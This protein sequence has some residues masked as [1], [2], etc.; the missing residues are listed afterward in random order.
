MR[1]KQFFRYL[2]LY[3]IMNKSK[4][5]FEKI[6]CTVEDNNEN[7]EKEMGFIKTRFVSTQF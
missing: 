4:I 5:Y 1:I 2:L 7:M 6:H 3:K